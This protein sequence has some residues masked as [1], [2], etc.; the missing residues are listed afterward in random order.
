M[1]HSTYCKSCKHFMM[2]HGNVNGK[3]YCAR[4]PDCKCKVKGDTYEEVLARL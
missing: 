1:E 4:G 3:G 2:E